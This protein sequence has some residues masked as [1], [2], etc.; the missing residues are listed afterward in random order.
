MDVDAASQAGSVSSSHLPS[1]QHQSNYSAISS[2]FSSSP[3]NLPLLNAATAFTNSSSSQQLRNHYLHNLT[4]KSSPFHRRLPLKPNYTTS[5]LIRS[6]V[7]SALS[8]PLATSS[9]I[10]HIHPSSSG[11]PKDSSQQLI[12]DILIRSVL[13]QMSQQESGGQAINWKRL[14]LC[15]GKLKASSRT[16]ALLS[17]F[18]MVAMVEVQ[19]CENQK[20]PIPFSLL[21]AFAICTTL[22]VSV[23]MLALMISTCLLPNVE[24]V[25]SMQGLVPIS[26]SPHE[27]LSYYV[28]IAWIFSTV[29]G[30][31]LFMIE[32]ILLCWV[33]FWD[34]G[35][36]DGKII[37]VTATILLIPIVAVFIG[38]AVHFYRNIVA[39]QYE[40]SAK[41]LE[42]LQV[43]VS[44]LKDDT[45][46]D[47]V[48]VDQRQ[49]AST[50]N[51]A[52]QSGREASQFDGRTSESP[53]P[54]T[55]VLAAQTTN[56]TFNISSS[57]VQ[58]DPSAPLLSSH[59]TFNHPSVIHT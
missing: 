34:V 33:K 17:G 23:H 8:I 37:A 5:S 46:T 55:S 16:S 50:A 2:I 25:A 26:E 18:A 21:I 38:F 10:S 36:M 1:S 12:Q 49:V 22:L 32:V 59:H 29:F 13:R 9:L 48:Q 43:M 27:K 45:L 56:L 42:E 44:Q 41:G 39:H 14:H 3:S 20:H 47:H 52:T 40:R 58:G 7:A 15:K 24:A 28:E 57:Q 19:L 54:A 35:G 31:L 30:I 11:A 51:V 4:P 6:A 53:P